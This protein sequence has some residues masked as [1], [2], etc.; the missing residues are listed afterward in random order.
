MTSF[1]ISH[2]AILDSFVSN[3]SSL[4]KNVTTAIIVF[5]E[6]FLMI[7]KC[8]LIQKWALMYGI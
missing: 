5:N 3:T 2:P 4:H 1:D 7:P 8:N 6:I